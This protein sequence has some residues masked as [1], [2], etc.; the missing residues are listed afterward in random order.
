MSPW[1]NHW[2]ILILTTLSGIAPEV[3]LNPYIFKYPC[4][5]AE[6]SCFSVPLFYHIHSL[7]NLETE[8]PSEN[9][10]CRQL[11]F[12]YLRFS[13]AL[14]LDEITN[15]ERPA[16]CY[17]GMRLLFWHKWVWKTLLCYY[18]MT[19]FCCLKISFWMCIVFIG[20]ILEN[21]GKLC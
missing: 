10:S 13:C 20:T 18:E 14:C 4:I 12:I 1:N 5:Q 17:L 6:T 8:A 2:V 16:S 9:H 19:I 7:S 15:C 11:H 3:K 21:N